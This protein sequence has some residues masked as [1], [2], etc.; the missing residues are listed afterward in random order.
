MFNSSLDVVSCLSLCARSASRSAASWWAA[1]QRQD[2]QQQQQ[3]QP[4]LQQQGV[5]SWRRGSAI[6][7]GA[8]GTVYR[9]LD[10]SSGQVFAVK[11]IRCEACSSKALKQLQAEIDIC[12]GLAHPNIIR[13][14]G[15]E[16]VDDNNHVNIFMEYM[17]GGSISSVL[18]DYGPLNHCILRLAVKGILSGLHYLHTRSP[19]IMHRDIK[20]ANVLVDTGFNVKLSDFGSSKQF[21]ITQSFSMV[22]SIPWMAP[23]VIAQKDGH[24]RKADIW[25]FGCT[26]IEMATAA[27]PWGAN[28]F[29]NAFMALHYIGFTEATPT[30]PES[31]PRSCVAFMQ[32]CL[33]RDTNVRASAE[34]L[35]GHAYVADDGH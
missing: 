2:Q 11:E 19:P 34:E 23:E 28:R 21:D 9:A 5:E 30:I 16:V 27:P 3:Q 8:Y 24:G 29:D 15:H 35:L 7:R 6:G 33:Q 12:R 25:S 17:S 20:S 10:L 31:L 1:R 14:I 4:Q 18:K 13:Y 26:I 22:G 32:S